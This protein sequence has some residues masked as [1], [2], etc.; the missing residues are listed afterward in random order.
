MID[1]PK[2]KRKKRRASRPG[3]KTLYRPSHCAK[4]I[5][6]LQAGATDMELAGLFGVNYTTVYDWKHRHPEF[7]QAIKIG[8]ELADERVVASLYHRAVGYN[9]Q[10]VKIFN[11]E[12]VPLV[13]PYEEHVPPD[14]SACV[15][16]LKN[17]R[18]K[19]WR[20]RVVQEISGPDGSS[21]PIMAEVQALGVEELRMMA[22]GL[23]ALD[24]P[25]RAEPQ[26]AEV[27]C[28]GK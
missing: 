11:S 28:G 20:D 3:P 15:F 7:A 22:N 5:K 8:R 18:P 17:R 23:R 1:E 6:F 27:I 25:G 9:H 21:I 19:E 4:A 26:D 10:A 14:I 12:G 2:K 16:W 24:V 13:V